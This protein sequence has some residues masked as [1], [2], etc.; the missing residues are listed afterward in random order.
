MQRSL[1][2]PT[3]TVECLSAGN[4]WGARRVVPSLPEVTPTCGS[5][6]R[7]GPM[8]L[9]GGVATRKSHNRANVTL[10]ISMDDGQQYRWSRLLHEGAGGYSSVTVVST[11]RDNRSVDAIC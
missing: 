11:T 2:Q 10:F 4:T 6:T 5:L 7:W 3:Y 8:L 9:Y 1:L